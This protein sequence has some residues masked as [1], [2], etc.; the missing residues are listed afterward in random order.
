[1]TESEKI[2]EIDNAGREKNW[3][4]VEND[5]LALKMF[6]EQCCESCSCKS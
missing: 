5:G 2:K 3:E 1:M 6:K 4:Q